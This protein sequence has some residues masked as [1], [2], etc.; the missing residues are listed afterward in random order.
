MA[1]DEP[2][3]IKSTFVDPGTAGT[4]IDHVPIGKLVVCS[5]LAQDGRHS[6]KRSSAAFSIVNKHV[7]R[8][9]SLQMITLSP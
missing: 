5:A 6:K 4:E 8:C 9:M 2:H 1:G 7:C 3:P